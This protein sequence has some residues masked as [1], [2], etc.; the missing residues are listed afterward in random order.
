MKTSEG[1]LPFFDIHRLTAYLFSLRA[2]AMRLLVSDIVFPDSITVSLLRIQGTLSDG[3]RL[4]GGTSTETTRPWY[5]GEA[6]AYCTSRLC[7]CD[8]AEEGATSTTMESDSSN[9][10]PIPRDQ[11]SP[12]N[13]S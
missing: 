11:L 4:I 7:H 12:G 9:A 3:M 1:F 6:R 5:L 2:L 8:F 10:F 13:R